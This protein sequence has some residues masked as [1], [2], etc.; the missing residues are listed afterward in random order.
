MRRFIFADMSKRRDTV[1]E[2]LSWGPL[3]EKELFFKEYGLDGEVHILAKIFKY[4][5]FVSQFD[6][7]AQVWDVAGDSFHSVEVEAPRCEVERALGFRDDQGLLD[8]V[9]RRFSG[10]FAVEQFQAFCRSRAFRFSTHEDGPFGDDLI[11]KYE[12]GCK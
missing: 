11:L 2:D 7:S 1:E 8:A 10:P 6:T 3:L 5:V 4:R 12:K 9:A